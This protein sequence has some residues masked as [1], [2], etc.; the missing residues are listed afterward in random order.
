[1]DRAVAEPWGS[2]KLVRYRAEGVHGAREA[3]VFGDYEVRADVID[4][5]TFEL[6]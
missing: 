6:A 5:G 4:R 3:V 1:M 2:G